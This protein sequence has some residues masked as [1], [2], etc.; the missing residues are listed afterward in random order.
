MIHRP[1]YSEFP[2]DRRA[3]FLAS[4]GRDSTA[5]I[6]EAY[7][8]GIKGIMLCN[9]VLT[10]PTARETLEKLRDYTGYELVLVKYE[11]K[12]SL[13]AIIEESFRKLPDVAQ[14][15]K[16]K[17]YDKNTFPCCHIVKRRAMNVA[18]KTL[19]DKEKDILILGLRS[20]EGN[21]NR[22]IILA[23]LRREKTFQALRFNGFLYYY[24]LRDCKQ[25]DVAMILSEHGFQGTKHSGCSICPI[26]VL[27]PQMAKAEPTRFLASVR[28]ARKLGVDVDAVYQTELRLCSR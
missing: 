7:A 8:E 17:R 24:P 15:V 2:K 6:L 27:F 21:K 23:K 10:L 20:G 4:G 9:D 12:R 13:A 3:L 11:G 16:E 25:S 26:L 18:L 28:Y 22:R 14:L 19:A 1:N 5:M